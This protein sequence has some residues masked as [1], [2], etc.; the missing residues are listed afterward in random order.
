MRP[1]KSEN[2]A[3]SGDIHPTSTSVIKNEEYCKVGQVDNDQ[4]HSKGDGPMRDG[5]SSQQYTK[6]SI[7]KTPVAAM[8]GLLHSKDSNILKI[9][10]NAE[11]AHDVKVIDMA[12]YFNFKHGYIV[13]ET[14]FSNF[15]S[16]KGQETYKEEAGPLLPVKLCTAHQDK[17]MSEM[18]SP[19]DVPSC[20]T[21]RSNS[22]TKTSSQRSELARQKIM[23][24]T[25]PVNAL[26]RP[27]H[28]DP[29]LQKS[30]VLTKRAWQ[31]RFSQCSRDSAKSRGKSKQRAATT[32]SRSTPH[33]HQCAFFLSRSGCGSPRARLPTPVAM[34]QSTEDCPRSTKTQRER[35]KQDSLRR[36]GKWMDE[37]EGNA[38]IDDERETNAK[39]LQEIMSRDSIHQSVPNGNIRY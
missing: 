30:L 33:S 13:K 14:S 38:V 26:F 2:K 23:L 31:S 27:H 9:K 3:H 35:S 39:K 12:K 15:N 34:L 25:R 24:P 19:Q 37:V 5:D 21:S 32:P 18:A 4:P 17:I 1:V 11:S 20:E 16:Q 29:S 36:I 28:A 10:T 8:G 6:Q 7:K 22:P